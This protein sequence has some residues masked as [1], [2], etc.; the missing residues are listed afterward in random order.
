MEEFHKTTPTCLSCESAKCTRFD[1][2]SRQSSFLRNIVFCSTTL[3]ASSNNSTATAKYR[4]FICKDLHGPSWALLWHFKL[5][6]KVKLAP[7]ENYLKF[8]IEHN[9]KLIKKSEINHNL[10]MFLIK[11][12]FIEFTDYDTAFQSTQSQII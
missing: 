2:W 6:N 7:Y 8:P 5:I 3:N 11:G 12:S 1:S 10:N 4:T 9:Q